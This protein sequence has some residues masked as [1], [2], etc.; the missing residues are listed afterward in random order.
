MLHWGSV[1]IAETLEELVD[2][3]YT[4]LLMW[5]FARGL[6]ARA[7]NSESSFRT[8][9]SFWM[10]PGRIR[11]LYSILAKVTCPGRISVLD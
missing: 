1:Q 5:D 7:F 6:A 8:Q 10:S 4:A 3:R 9:K 2:P 11:S